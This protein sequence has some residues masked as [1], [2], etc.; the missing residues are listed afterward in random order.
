[1]ICSRRSTQS[2]Q[3]TQRELALRFPRV[4]REAFLRGSVALPSSE[5]PA[6]RPGEQA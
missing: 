3:N 1:M 2:V 6:W 4:R 5:F